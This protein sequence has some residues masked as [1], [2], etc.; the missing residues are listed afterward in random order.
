MDAKS[1]HEHQ[2][3]MSPKQR[4]GLHSEA[5]PV[6]EFSGNED[7]E[8]VK[9]NPE[10]PPEESEPEI[11]IVETIEPVIEKAPAPE[12]EPAPEEESREQ[13]EAEEYEEEKPNPWSPDAIAERGQSYRFAST[14]VPRQERH[15]SV[16]P[17][18]PVRDNANAVILI[19][20]IAILLITVSIYAVILAREE[21]APA[22]P[23]QT[24]VSD[25]A[26]D[27][28]DK[29]KPTPA[30][31]NLAKTFGVWRYTNG[32]GC[33]IF[34]EEGYFYWYQSCSE[35]SNNYHYG[36]LMGKRGSQALYEFNMT[37]DDAVTAMKLDSGTV[38]KESFFSLN[39]DTAETVNAGVK[40]STKLSKYKMLFAYISDSEAVLYD[41]N[42]EDAI[43]HLE[44][45]SDN[46]SE[47]RKSMASSSN[48]DMPTTK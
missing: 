1:L 12:P 24:V 5:K 33:F 34:S 17:A 32:G 26:K 43:Y 10:L 40:R 16:E 29:Q 21:K 30:D 9:N 4:L 11:E 23:T 6:V 28:E 13:E 15:Y 31:P 36:L 7:I 38:T 27:D 22:S 14:S 42:T 37:F 2:G 41:I 35:V 3:S 25:E 19:L 20:L 46:P 39:L 48:P 44:K 8:P 45:I 47:W 18:K